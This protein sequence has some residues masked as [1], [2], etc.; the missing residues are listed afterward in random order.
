M[1]FSASAISCPTAG[2][3]SKFK[4]KEQ[5]FSFTTKLNLSG[6]GRPLGY[7]REKIISLT[8]SFDYYNEKDQLIAKAS[9][10]M[11]SWGSKLEVFDC[12]GKKIGSIQE[13]IFASLFS[14]STTYTIYNS[15]DKELAKSIKTE[16]AATNFKIKNKDEQIAEL[17]RPWFNITDSWSVEIKKPILDSRLLVMIGAFKTASDNERKSKKNNH[18]KK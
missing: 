14:I 6:E 2:L 11:F 1:I 17:H 9:K 10:A 8:T 16:I 3:P 13:E 7:V 4:L 12:D 18:H 15:L 5:F